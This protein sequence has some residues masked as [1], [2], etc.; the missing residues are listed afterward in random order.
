MVVTKP[1]VYLETSLYG[2]VFDTSDLD[3]HYWTQQLFAAVK[4]D[5]FIPY[6]SE[7]V[8][9]ELEATRQQ[10]KRDNML[11]LIGQYAIEVLPDSEEVDRLAAIYIAKGITPPSKV[12]DAFH[13]ATASV[14]GL[15]T[16]ASYNFEHIA[17]KHKKT[18]ITHVAAI[19]NI[20]AQ[21]NHQPIRI[22][23]P[24]EILYA[25]P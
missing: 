14:Y 9:R 17:K 11:A 8:I 6:A 23:T 5:R 21:E 24:E 4:Q 10:P 25:H 13:I 22:L 18:R 15:S 16:I 7:Y 20:N 3:L 2:W 12:D 19:N 1:K